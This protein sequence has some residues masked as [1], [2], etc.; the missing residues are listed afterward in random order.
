MLDIP[1]LDLAGA[2]GVVIGIAN[3]ASIAYGCARAF[4]SLGAELAVTYLNEK[5]KRFVEPLAQ[6]L[7][8]E[9]FLPCNVQSEGEM[10]AVFA[11]VK[12]RWG[13]LDFAL[14]SIAY[15]PMDDLHGRIVDCSRDGFLTAMEVSCHSFIRMCHLAEPLMTEGGTLFTMSYYGADKVVEHYNIMGPVKAALESHHALPGI[16]TRSER[17]PRSR[18]LARPIEDPRCLRH[19]SFRRTDGQGRR[20]RT[21]RTLVTSE[22][23]GITTAI[24][25]THA[26]R[27]LTGA[28]TYVDGGYHVMG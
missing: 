14:H 19:R 8:A 21:R 17:H 6:S 12:R 11:E 5:A 10:E 1:T 18:H 20:P 15:A 2:K 16:R 26:G 22:D 28:T 7:E 3:D 9:I 4:R 23:V 27:M 13:R 25:A 24:L